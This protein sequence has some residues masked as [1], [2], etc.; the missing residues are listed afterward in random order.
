MIAAIN[1]R[2]VNL[3][4][5]K[6][7]LLTTKSKFRRFLTKLEAKRPRGLDQL[8]P[9]L[10]KEVWEEI[11]CLT[12]ANCCKTMS[13]TFNKK[14][15]TRI[16]AHL[17][18]TEAAFKDKWLYLEKKDNDWMNRKQPCQFLNLQTNMCNIYEVRPADCAGFP[19]LS[20][21]KYVDYVHVHKQN[22]QY[23]PATHRMV[24]KM[25][26]VVPV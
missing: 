11:D 9:V 3:R 10:E 1:T 13:P 5:F 8:T 7:Q 19:H 2:A 17:G 20:K 22:I 4:K 18:M 23:C 26:A 15:I 14:D 6:K 12:C 21:K 25:K 16:S 24:E